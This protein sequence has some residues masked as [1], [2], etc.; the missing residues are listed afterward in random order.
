M[1]VNKILGKLRPFQNRTVLVSNYQNSSDIIKEIIKA[2]AK[3][4]SEY[5]KI[6]K[7]FWKGS[8]R[9][10]ANYIFDY[11]KKNVNYDIEP[12]TKQTVKSPSAIVAQGYGDCKHYSLFTAGILDS[13]RRSGKPINWAYRFANYKLF[14]RT[15]HHVFVVMDPKTNNETWID[16]VLEFFDNKKP[17]VNATDKNYKQMALY[18]ISG[19][20]KLSYR[21]QALNRL[22]RIR[23]QYRLKGYNKPTSPYYKR[24]QEIIKRYNYWRKKTQVSGFNE[25]L[26]MQSVAGFGCCGDCVGYTAAQRKTDMNNL[27]NKMQ[28][29]KRQGWNNPAS[30]YYNEYFLARKEYMR[31]RSL[32]TMNGADEFT[33]TTSIEGIGRRSRAERKA[34]RRARREAR[35]SGPNCKGRLAAKIALSVPRRAFLLLVRINFKKLGV[36]IYKGLNDPNI[37]P[38]IYSKWCGLGGN[39]ALLRRTAEKAYQKAKRRGKVSGDYDTDGTIGVAITT[40]VATASA[41][42]AALDPVLKL[43]KGGGEETEQTTTSAE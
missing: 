9:A 21:Q 32:P 38:K 16:P 18:S 36:K 29:Y 8:A 42:L 1:E 28:N 34:R 17:Y 30:P 37:S 4:S 3:Y 20:G 35:R 12:D 14:A 27:W 19:V 39:A 25:N 23:Q 7:Y 11:L 40:V 24:Y 26:N 41:I 6:S 33:A 22:W 2:H 10:T 43:I 5:D 31:V 13:L 15:P